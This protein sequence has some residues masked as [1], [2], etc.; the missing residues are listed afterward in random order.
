MEYRPICKT[1]IGGQ[2]L[3]RD[4]FSNR[5][6]F[7]YWWRHSHCYQRE[8]GEKQTERHLT[9]IWAMQSC[10]AILWRPTCASVHWGGGQWNIFGSIKNMAWCMGSGNIDLITTLTITCMTYHSWPL[11]VELIMHHDGSRV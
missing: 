7:H 11:R 1:Q 10:R 9:Q 6:P 4:H 8:I 5:V 2:P 3:I